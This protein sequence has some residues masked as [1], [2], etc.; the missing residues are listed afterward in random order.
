MKQVLAGRAKGKKKIHMPMF[1]FARFDLEGVCVCPKCKE[2]RM[3]GLDDSSDE[4]D[5]LDD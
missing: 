3:L 1:D 4:E 5:E 2:E